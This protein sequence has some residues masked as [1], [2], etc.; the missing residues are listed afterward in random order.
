M[1]DVRGTLEPFVLFESSGVIAVFKPA[2]LPTQSP[3]GIESAEAWLRRRHHC[4]SDA[5][6]AMGSAG[7]YVGIPHRLDRAVSGVLLMATTPR[8]ARKLA[9]QFERRQIIKTYVAI[10]ACTGS[11][12]GSAESLE[13][14]CEQGVEW[15]DLIEKVPDQARARIVQES[16]SAAREAV[17]HATLLAKLFGNDFFGRRQGPLCDHWLVELSPLTGRMHQLRVQAAW[18]GMPGA[19]DFLYGNGD[20]C[21]TADEQRQQPIALH[22]LSI[23]FADP[24]TGAMKTVASPLPDF[25]P[26]EVSGMG[27]RVG[28]TEL[29]AIRRG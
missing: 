6:H 15:R 18:R 9:R 28:L 24:D 23:Q 29:R 8:A 27:L 22:A 7:G 11:D 16:G 17:T 13:R 21:R 12:K 5:G 2:G 4:R 26:E 25:W 1:N 3:A 10:V 19:G 20:H 14:G